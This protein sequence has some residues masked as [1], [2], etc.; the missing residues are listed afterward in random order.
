MKNIFQ[1]FAGTVGI[2]M[3]G[4]GLFIGLLIL[5]PVKAEQRRQQRNSVG[6]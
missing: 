4:L 3:V 5:I 2:G 6:G 1:H